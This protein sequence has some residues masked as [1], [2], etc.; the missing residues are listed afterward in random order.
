MHNSQRARDLAKCL[1]PVL[2]NVRDV[3]SEPGSA[4][5]YSGLEKVIDPAEPDVDFAVCLELYEAWNKGL[6]R[7]DGAEEQATG[8]L[9]D[10]LAEVLEGDDHAVGVLWALLAGCG[11]RPPADP[12]RQALTSSAN[13]GSA[14]GDRNAT[15][16]S[17]APG[18]GKRPGGVSH[19]T[20]ASLRRGWANICMNAIVALV[21]LLAWGLA[22]RPLQVRPPAGVLAL[23]IF[24]VWSLSFLP[25]WLYI[26]FLGQRAGA[27][28]DEYV[29]N[30]HRLRWDSPRH[31][32]KPPVNSDFYA[33]W[34]G[35][36]GALMVHRSNIY[37][38]KFDAYYGRSVSRSGH[39][40]GP[41]VRIET[42]FPVFLTTAVLA[43]CW[44]AVLWSPRFTS[45]PASVWDVLKF[46]FLGAYSFILQM[47]VRRFFQSDLRP[48]AYANAL[49]RLIVVLILV[50][51]LFQVMPQDNL[52]GAAAIAFL[53]GFFPLVG[54][55]A[56]QRFAATAL[57]V[58]V[59]SL[60]PAYPLNQIDGLSVWYE[61]RL[62]EEG[63]EDMQSLATANF[64]DVILHTRVPVGRLVD[65]V[66]Q[67]HLYLHLDRIEGT[68][69]ERRHAKTGKGPA[70]AVQADRTAQ[71]DVTVH[72]DVT[73]Q[74]DG[75]AQAGSTMPAIAAGSVTESSR[76]GSKTRT[77][78][79]QF[80][81]RKATDLIKAFP[82]EYVDPGRTLKPGSPWRKHLED[83][84]KAG[85]D[86]A[87]LRTI[88]RVLSREPSLAPVW[89]WQNRGVRTCEPAARDR[90]VVPRPRASVDLLGRM[91]RAA[92]VRHNGST[93]SSGRRGAP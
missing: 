72:A 63:I 71:A 65:W 21:L 49:L 14:P 77:A 9:C 68:W 33:E 50:T 24:T 87:Q 67:A 36:G 15:D 16:G 17:S 83:A 6:S 88:V 42:L 11:D 81:I 1:A 44:T 51:A 54:M 43:V 20:R 40:E 5:C 10:H 34:L 73:V 86:Q 28:W 37:Q 52:R 38:Q 82:P 8:T 41:P 76:A 25:G 60:S 18:R 70:D 22:W 19:K 53:I 12:L 26:R 64:V 57:R 7:W 89:N 45:D 4:D 69:R 47:L 29:L 62:L 80:G 92:V 35:D 66:D 27:L 31:L 90:P 74:A 93:R 59:P 3:N 13:G 30:L 39:G 48:A 79:R 56:M 23:E 55:Q 58:V 78:L 46:G 2:E 91:P 61:A 84:A 85:L 75:T 32:P